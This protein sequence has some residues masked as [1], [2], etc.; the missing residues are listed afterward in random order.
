MAQ[1]NVLGPEERGHRPVNCRIAPWLLALACALAPAQ[2]SMAGGGPPKASMRFHFEVSSAMPESQRLV[3]QL[4]NPKIAVSVGKFPELWEKHIIGVE[5]LAAQPG[6]VLLR[7]DDH[8]K[9]VLLF[10]T[11]ANKGRRLVVVLN[12]KPIFA[13]T[14]DATLPNGQLV[15]PS[16]ITPQDLESLQR[17]AKKNKRENE[18]R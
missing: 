7:F 4:E 11:E 14:V 2:P 10:L 9:R 13:P 18:S 12:G 1:S 8:G 17:I 15:I 3:Y 5:P 16:G 6:A